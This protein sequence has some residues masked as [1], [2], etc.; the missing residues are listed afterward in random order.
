[1]VL[2]LRY[3]DCILS[4]EINGLTYNS[5][6]MFVLFFISPLILRI[7]LKSHLRERI[8]YYKSIDR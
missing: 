8:G 3:D 1:M 7:I 5:E 2:L 4:L 6:Y